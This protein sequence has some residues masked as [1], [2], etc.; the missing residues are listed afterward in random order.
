LKRTVQ[1][2]SI[3]D[4]QKVHRLVHPVDVAPTMA[5]FLGMTPPGASQG[6]PL[7]EVLR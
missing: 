7:K 6:S 2:G 3:V 5:A 4:A 1:E